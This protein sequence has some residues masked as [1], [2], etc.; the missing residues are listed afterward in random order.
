MRIRYVNNLR[1]FGDLAPDVV[2]AYNEVMDKV[3]APVVEAIGN[4]RDQASGYSWAKLLLYGPVFGTALQSPESTRSAILSALRT[5][6]NRMDQLRADRAKVL[7]GSIALNKWI[8]GV[9]AIFDGVKSLARDLN[10]STLLSESI[11]TFNDSVQ[12]GMATWERLK[13]AASGALQQAGKGLE[14]LPWIGGA[15]ILAAIFI[16]PR[17]LSPTIVVRSG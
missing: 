4:L 3:Y 8:G 16:L 1:G 2:N 13:Q 6:G 17:L 5:L 12:Q 11:A 14:Y 10:E 15:A 9:S 7:S